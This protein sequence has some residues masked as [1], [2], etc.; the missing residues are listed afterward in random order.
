MGL[1][2]EQPTSLH[3]AVE[4]DEAESMGDQ[5]VDFAKYGITGAL[6]SGAVSFV[7]TGKAFA[8]MFGSE[9][10]YTETADVL[11]NSGWDNAAS[12]YEE[13]K[14]ALD[15]VGLVATSFV[16]GAVGIKAARAVQAGLK[17]AGSNSRAV[18]GLRKALVPDDMAKKYAQRLQTE[19]RYF[20][21]DYRYMLDAA[22]QGMHQQAV[23]TAFAEAAILT[24]MNQNPTLTGKDLDYLGAI[25][26]NLSSAGFG[27]VLGTGIAGT[28]DAAKN[29]K[30]LR[31]IVNNDIKRSNELINI[32]DVDSSS[33]RLHIAEGDRISM[34]A[35]NEEE[36]RKNLARAESGDIE[37]SRN[38]V[39]EIKSRLKQLD[40]EL[41]EHLAVLASDPVGTPAALK[42]DSS[43]LTPALKKVYKQL[44]PEDRQNLFSGLKRATLY[45]EDEMLMEPASNPVKFLDN[46]ELEDFYTNNILGLPSGTKPDRAQKLAAKKFA[47]E[48]K[49]NPDGTGV[50]GFTFPN[51]NNGNIGTGINK[52]LLEGDKATALAVMRHEF[53][54]NNTDRI[55]K[56]F[57]TKYGSQIKDQLVELSRK[58]R[59]SQWALV[60]RSKGIREGMLQRL[61][62]ME[63][64][65]DVLL[66]ELGEVEDFIAKSETYLNRPEEL[67]ADSWAVMNDPTQ[68][69]D[70]VEQYKDIYTVFARNNAIRS[71]VGDTETLLDLRTGQA[72]TMADRAP[73]IRDLGKV[74]M[75]GKKSVRHARGVTNVTKKFDPENINFVDASAHYYAAARNPIITGKVNFEATELPTFLKLM[76]GAKRAADDGVKFDPVVSLKDIDGNTR[77]FDF[78]TAREVGNTDEVL[79]ELRKEMVRTKGVLAN[80]LANRKENK[81]GDSDISRILDTDYEFSASKGIDQSAA[82][83]WS[84][85]YDP[86]RPTVAK[87][88][89]ASRDVATDEEMRTIAATQHRISEEYK[90][91][92]MQ[93]DTFLGKYFGDSIQFPDNAQL[94]RTNTMTEITDI[95]NTNGIARSFQGDYD[96]MSKVQQIGATD[97]K[98]QREGLKRIEREVEATAHNVRIDKDALYEYSALDAKLRQAKYFELPKGVSFLDHVFSEYAA[99]LGITRETLL[100]KFAPMQDTLKTLSTK[101]GGNQAANLMSKDLEAVIEKLV[102]SKRV[103]GSMRTRFEELVESDVVAVK[104]NNLAQFMRSANK[105]NGLVRD[106]DETVKTARGLTST[107]D[108]RVWYPGPLD[109]SRYKHILYVTP[110][111]EGIFSTNK[112]AI[113]GAPDEDA[114]MV[115]RQQVLDSFGEDVN[116]RTAEEQKEYFRRIG[117]YDPDEAINE[118]NVNSTMKNRGIAWDVAPEPTPQMVDSLVQGIRNQW[119]G[120]ARQLTRLK[121]SEEFAT[122]ESLDKYKRLTSESVP[123]RSK[124]EAPPSS[125][126]QIMD[127]MLNVTNSGKFAKWLEGQENLDRAFSGMING[128]TSMFKSAKEPLDFQKLNEIRKQYGMPEVYNDTIKDYIVQ[129]EKVN[130]RILASTIPMMNTVAGSLMLRL[131]LIQPVVNV[132]SLPILA[133]PEMKHVYDSLP[134]IQK[135]QMDDLVTVRNPAVEGASEQSNTRL[136]Y[137]AAKDFWKRKD[138]REEYENLDL[139]GTMLREFHDA[140]DSVSFTPKDMGNLQKVKDGTKKVVDML[141]QPADKTEQFVRFVAARMADITLERGGVT[142]KSLRAEVMRTFVNRT[143]GNYT[144]AQRP[145]MFQGFA[146]Q[147][148]GLFQTYQFNLIQQ[149]LRHMGTDN[150]RAGAMMA[151]QGGIFGAQ[152]VP[153]FELLNQHIADRSTGDYNDFF[154]GANDLLGDDLSQWLLY[155]AASN[156]TKPITGD[157]IALYTRGNLNPRTPTI[158]PTSLDEVPAY[159][160]TTKFL[161]S[162]MTAADKLAEGAP[163]GQVFANALA[164][165][166]VNRPLSGLGQMLSGGRTTRQGSLLLATDDL[167]WWQKATRLAGAKGLDES[168]AV[169]NFYR[170]KQYESVRQERVNSMGQAVKDMIRGGTWD[171]E[172]YSKFYRKYTEQGGSPD[173]FSRWVTNQAMGANQSQIHKLYRNHN[174]SEGRYLQR[175]M[176]SDIESYIDPMYTSAGE[177]ATPMQ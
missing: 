33:A 78:K 161:G 15:M 154:T 16:P 38:N 63:T 131:D 162:I 128:F 151:L 91:A 110:K 142:N 17:A 145:A 53:G 168:I 137:Q 160:M 71:R 127:T 123:G 50:R 6:T 92:N 83:S 44:E 93:V 14:T 27:L 166:G 76:K 82:E 5:I 109:R 163:A 159:S 106:A 129:T 2:I 153:G 23:E 26:E 51:L 3:K 55:A 113:I 88:R 64:P 65:D 122:L 49:L 158:I 84:E 21:K 134:D 22:K 155:G 69:N 90:H 30:V 40:T 62:K 39:R 8:N 11:R 95:T 126:Q 29:Y 28:M 32:G 9:Y 66:K 20:D 58:A 24:T 132:L 48:T 135:R 119:I 52:K 107:I 140:V 80:R 37:A 115:K 81:L 175:I 144:Y 98:L 117:E 45:G 10:E 173:Y 169:Q 111:R 108:S 172:E 13:H 171:N 116:I 25:K 73:T 139:T 7:N 146:G 85:V 130:D 133:V 59:P 86:A 124:K 120:K 12:Y 97:A 112:P 57:E 165:N 150:A 94:S 164:Q 18:V 177:T 121:Y 34:L 99:P 147:A 143:I 19:G 61:S 47:E 75:I 42:I 43:T 148:V 101:L 114:L 77:T 152:S 138:L 174:S 72:F 141:S 96:A 167:S 54:H 89:Y 79:A 70:L 125:Y 170:L 102:T 105:A 35:A 36:A 87:L 31:S 60:D 68:I 56:V 104:N 157:G 156:F 67:L 41:E 149:M 1:Y 100:E 176:G 46:S 136:L 4:L 74:E 103:S 118:F